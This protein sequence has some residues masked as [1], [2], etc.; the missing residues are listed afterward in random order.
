MNS[1]D[2]FFSLSFDTLKNLPDAV[3]I[4][5]NV[6]MIDNTET[7]HITKLTNAWKN[8][9]VQVDAIMT[10]F[11]T[12]GEISV[13]IGLEN[14]ILQKNS[15]CII[16][17]GNIVEVLS[18]SETF[19]CI[20]M[21]LSKEF[22]NTELDYTLQAMQLHKYLQR[23]PCYTLTGTYAVRYKETIT[24]AMKTIQWE[25]NPLR[26]KMMQSYA[27]LLFCCLMPV[28]ENDERSFRQNNSTSHQKEIYFKFM[29]LLQV[30][31]REHH[32]VAYYA[33]AL[34]ITPKHLTKVV[35]AESGQTAM[36][37][38]ENYIIMEAKALLKQN[39]ANIL[40]ISEHLN[41]PDQSSFGKFFRRVTGLSP[42]EY[43]K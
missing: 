5:D 29:E 30:E 18:V 16:L 12:E 33:E 13:R 20:T 11:C 43:R 34:G 8:F 24:E 40:T 3:T 22:V 37:W 10:I 4:E 38:I 41:F 36:R 26:P 32:T 27:Y 1:N 14:Y 31:Y 9:P 39:N 2:I 15:V 35:N 17:A 6:I 21:V 42:K 19:H 7:H 25:E 23:Q 28:L